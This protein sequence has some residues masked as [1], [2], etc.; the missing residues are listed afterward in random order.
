M[1]KIHDMQNIDRLYAEGR[2]KRLFKIET[3]YRVEIPNI[4]EYL[5]TTDKEVQ[6]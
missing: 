5:N 3:T 6:F 1:Y 4:A 2:T